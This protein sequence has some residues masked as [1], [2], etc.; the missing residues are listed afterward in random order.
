MIDKDIKINTHNRTRIR[1]IQILT[2][3]KKQKK[4]NNNLIGG[5]GKD[6]EGARDSTPNKSIITRF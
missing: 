2:L 5:G 1:K 6:H 3:L 4:K